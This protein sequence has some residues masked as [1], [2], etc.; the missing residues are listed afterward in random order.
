MKPVSPPKIQ[1]RKRANSELCK[2]RSQWWK[3]FNIPPDQRLR[4][5]SIVKLTC[6]YCYLCPSCST[7]NWFTYAS[8]QSLS[9]DSILSRI[10]WTY[11]DLGNRIWRILEPRPTR[12]HPTTFISRW[13][14]FHYTVFYTQKT[15]SHIYYMYT[16]CPKSRYKH[17]GNGLNRSNL[18]LN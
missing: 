5:I 13:P 6:S 9:L 14:L 16:G 2:H 7:G 12:P 11:Y 4:G 15:I 17:S 18:K 8:V 10:L 3:S 1:I